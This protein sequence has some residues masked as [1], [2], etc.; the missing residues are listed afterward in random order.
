MDRAQALR[1][2]GRLAAGVDLGGTEPP[3]LVS[4][5]AR[6][7]AAG[8]GT[9]PKRC[10]EALDGRDVERCDEPLREPDEFL[11]CSV[12]RKRV[13]GGGNRRGSLPL[14]LADLGRERTATG[15]QLEPHGF[16]GLAREPQLAALGI[17]TEAFGRHGG[18]G[19]IEQLLLRHDGKLGDELGRIASDEDDE[20]SEARRARAFDERERRARVGREQRRRAPSQR[21]GDRALAALGHVDHRQRE[22]LALFGQRTRGGRK[23]FALGERSLER[24]EPFAR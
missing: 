16:R 14:Q 4:E 20:I 15:L 8:I 2:L 17:P 19:R 10:L 9:G 11:R 12:R 6:P 23:P 18:N 1:R 3:Q 22:P 13:R 21:R 24:G 5:L 7:R